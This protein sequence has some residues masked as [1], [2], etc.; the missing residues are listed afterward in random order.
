MQQREHDRSTYQTVWK[1]KQPVSGASSY[2][3]MM[4]IRMIRFRVHARK[5]K[6]LILRTGRHRKKRRQTDSLWSGAEIE[7]ASSRAG[8]R[9]RPT[10]GKP[11]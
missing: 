5:H 6:T 10:T 3:P 9:G 4:H 11:P 7:P 8:Q 1:V 2:G